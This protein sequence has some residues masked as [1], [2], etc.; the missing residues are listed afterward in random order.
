MFKLLKLCLVV[1]ALAAVWMLVP[2]GGRTLQAR[3]T[4]AGS[5][6]AFAAGCWGELKRAADGAP[7]KPKTPTPA[8]A[9]AGERAARP[10]EQHSERDRQAVDR[11]VSEHLKR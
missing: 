8:Q 1:G 6:E 4:A 7:A 10:A 2:V 3:W 5:A 9:R 11:I